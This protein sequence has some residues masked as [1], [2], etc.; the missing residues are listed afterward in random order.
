M[1][2]SLG[3]LGVADKVGVS[4]F[5]SFGDCLFRDK[6]DCVGDFNL[7]GGETVFTSS[8][9]QA[10]KFVCGGNFLGYFLGDRTKILQ[11]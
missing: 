11:R 9:C 3:H 8:L 7:F 10:E 5:L 4:F 1:C 6:K 2:F